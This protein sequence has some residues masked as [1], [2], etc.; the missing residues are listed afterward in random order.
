W[1]HAAGEVRNLAI[2]GRGRNCLNENDRSDLPSNLAGRVHL[3]RIAEVEIHVQAG[4]TIWAN[5]HSLREVHG[6]GRDGESALNRAKRW[7]VCAQ[8]DIVNNGIR[9]IKGRAGIS[10]GS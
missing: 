3:Q 5:H 2:R 8:V 10:L 6:H 1:Y 9:E 4:K 7:R